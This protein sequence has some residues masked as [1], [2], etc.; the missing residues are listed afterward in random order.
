M[1]PKSRGGGLGLRQVAENNKVILI[2]QA[3]VW[4]PNDHHC[5]HNG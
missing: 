5:G 1:C 3:W 2:K 4:L